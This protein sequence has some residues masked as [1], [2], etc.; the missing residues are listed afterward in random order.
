M[1]RPPGL[2]W[3]SLLTFLSILSGCLANS[4]QIDRS[5]AHQD[6]RKRFFDDYVLNITVLSKEHPFFGQSIFA[7]PSLFG[8]V[9]DSK[10]IVPVVNLGM[11][12]TCHPFV[13]T[14]PTLTDDDAALLESNPE[15]P[16]RDFVEMEV[17]A[18]IDNLNLKKRD[19]KDTITWMALSARGGCAFDTKVFHAQ[20]AGFGLVGIYN[21]GISSGIYQVTERTASRAKYA[22]PSDWRWDLPLRMASSSYGSKVRIPSVFFTYAEVSRILGIHPSIRHTPSSFVISIEPVP[23][24]TYKTANMNSFDSIISAILFYISMAMLT[25]S[26][27]M[28]VG[29]I[30]GIIRHYMLYGTV[31]EHDL[32]KPLPKMDKVDFPLKVFTQEDFAHAEGEHAQ[33]PCCA[34]CIEDFEV[35]CKARLLPCSHQF[36]DTW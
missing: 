11:I 32:P 14:M 34:I 22:D 5:Q 30:I 7:V 33:D 31:Q 21:D 9:I 10:R 29:V 4:D 19:N 28:S 17:L 25:A 2:F 12:E 15:L 35:G 1:L 24:D 13:H 3:I 23:R 16:K 6:L 8:E 26:V 36:H 18:D 20:N 27:L